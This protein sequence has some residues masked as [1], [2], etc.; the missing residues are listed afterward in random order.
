LVA[1]ASASRYTY[2]VGNHKV[3]FEATAPGAISKETTADVRFSHYNATFDVQTIHVGS[4]AYLGIAETNDPS[5][6]GNSFDTRWEVEDMISDPKLDC[7]ETQIREIPVNGNI[8]RKGMCDSSR[9][10][11]KVFMCVFKVDAH[12]FGSIVVVGN[13][14]K[15]E[16]LADSVKTESI[17]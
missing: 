1:G 12:A 2:T 6:D 17:R 5:F 11:A 13:E 4:N 3:T 15:F 8:C 10:G 7:S 16:E 14:T 9:M